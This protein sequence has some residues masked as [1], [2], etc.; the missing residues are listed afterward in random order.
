MTSPPQFAIFFNLGHVRGLERADMNGKTFFSNVQDNSKLEWIGVT[1][2][3]EII[4]KN[5]KNDTRF[6]FKVD[7]ILDHEWD[8]LLDIMENKRSPKIMEHITR[9]VGYYSQLRNWNA[10]KLAELEDRHLGVYGVPEKR[11]VEQ[12][13]A[14]T[15]A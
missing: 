7:A 5:L 10:S 3:D 4:V 9:I 15:A 6:A 1:D 12:L 11:D 14:T 13:V 8:T 2:T